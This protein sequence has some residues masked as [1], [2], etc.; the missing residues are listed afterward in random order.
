MTL[1]R[2]LLGESFNMTTHSTWIRVRV[3]RYKRYTHEGMVTGAPARHSAV[4][5]T[6]RT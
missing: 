5:H 2:Q 4:R 3:G 1:G 6:M